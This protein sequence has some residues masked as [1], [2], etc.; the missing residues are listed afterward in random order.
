MLMTIEYGIW[1]GDRKQ[2]YFEDFKKTLVSIYSIIF[3]DA[4]GRTLNG[5][6]KQPQLDSRF[7]FNKIRKTS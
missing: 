5:I 1:N 7:A 2:Y 3:T 4:N 6:H